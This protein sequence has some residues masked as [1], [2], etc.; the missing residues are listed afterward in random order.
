MKRKI[1]LNK[2]IKKQSVSWMLIF[3]TV[4]RYTNKKVIII[5]LIFKQLLYF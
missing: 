2:L 4:I 1:T 5:H 3:M